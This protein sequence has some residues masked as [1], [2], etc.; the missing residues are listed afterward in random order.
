LE[1]GLVLTSLYFV[2]A[3]R[4]F[5]VLGSIAATVATAFGIA[6]FLAG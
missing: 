6:G 1:L 5:P 3:R 2:S 4:F